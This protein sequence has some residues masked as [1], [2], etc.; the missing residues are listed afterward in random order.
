DAVLHLVD[1]ALGAH[2]AAAVAEA[3]R[4]RLELE[5]PRE[6]LL[7]AGV[8]GQG[9][10]TAIAAEVG[11]R[12]AKLGPRLQQVDA[13]RFLRERGGQALLLAA[14]VAQ[15]IGRPGPEEDDRRDRRG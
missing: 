7:G 5:R 8:V 15:R 11:A 3:R 13:V 1:R 14:P 2:D 6:V 12:E 10:A 9:I 4:V